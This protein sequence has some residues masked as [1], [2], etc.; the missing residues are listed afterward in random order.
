MSISTTEAKSA[1]TKS[2]HHRAVLSG[3]KANSKK[4]IY[5]I[6]GRART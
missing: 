4:K 1:I 6:L 2:H 3:A 5:I